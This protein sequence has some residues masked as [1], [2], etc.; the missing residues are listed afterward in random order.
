MFNRL[1]NSFTIKPRILF[2]CL[3]LTG[4]W[5]LSTGSLYAQEGGQIKQPVSPTSNVLFQGRSIDE[6]CREKNLSFVQCQT[7]KSELSKSGG[8]PTPEAIEAL[9]KSPE[10]KDLKPE[11]IAKGKELLEKKEV[12]EPAKPEVPAGEDTLFDRYISGISP[13]E[14]RI[15]LKSSEGIPVEPDYII[16]TGDKINILL[17]GKANAQYSLTVGSDGTILFPNVGPLYVEGM[18]FEEVKKLL[19]KQTEN[20][21]GIT[22]L[23]PFGYNLFTETT[24]APQQNLPIASDYIIGPSDEINIFLWGRINAQYNLIVSR[25]GTIQVPNMG[26]LSVAGMTFE[27]VKKFLAKQAKN[28]VGAE[29]N[30]TM[31]MLRSIQV[32]VLG[33]VKKPG[34]YTVSAMSTLT[35]ALM[36]SGGPTQIGTLR[37]VELKRNNNKTIA[38][39]DFYDLLLKGDK[40]KDMRL[41]N[42]DVVFVPTAGPLV[43]VAGNVKRPAIYELKGETDLAG[44]LELAG[45]IIP[46]AYTQQIQVERVE[47]NQRRIVV[48]LNT[49]ERDIA[50]TF[51]LQ[52]ADLVKVFSIVDKDTNVVY[53]HGNVKRPGKYEL[54]K[55]MRL[56]N[57]IKDESELLQETYFEYGLIKRLVPPSFEVKLIP[58]SLGSL[59]FKSSQED[60]IELTPRDSIYI[61]SKWLFKD[62]PSASI[63]GEVRKKGSFELGDNFSVKDLVLLA[64]D[65]TKEAY[66]KKAEIVRVN[67]K[68]EYQ[69]I[70]FNLVKAMAGDKSENLILQD[71]DKVIIHSMWEE[72]WKEIVTIVGEVKK[73]R[74]KDSQQ[75]GKIEDIRV[76]RLQ[77]DLETEQERLKKVEEERKSLLDKGI[78]TPTED[79]IKKLDEKIERQKQKIQEGED[80]LSKTEKEIKESM[81]FLLTDEMTI[82]DLMFKAGG[83]TRDT[84]LEEA[85]L[86]RTDWKT[87]EV[88]LLKFNL[89]KAMEGDEVNNIK[90]QDLDRV[91]IHSI[92][93]KIPR[94]Y[95]TI[96]GEVNKPGQYSYAANMTVRDFVFAAGSLFESAYLEEAELSSYIVKE[97][98]SSLISYRKVNLREAMAGEPSQNIRL[99]P[100]DALFI[101]RVPEWKEE[102]YIII[103]GEVVFPGRYIFKKGERLSS[104]IERAG[105][106][107]DKAYLN[108]ALFTRESVRVLQQKNLD[109]SIDRMEQMLL[110]QTVGAVETA[111]TPEAS[112]QQ[113]AAIEQRKIL[114]SKLRATKA[115]GRLTIK[116][117]TPGK[118][119]GTSH[120][121]EIEDKDTIYIPLQ[122]SSVIVIGAVF[123]QNAFL[124]DAKGNVSSYIKLAG[125]MTREADEKSIFILK[126]DGTA[127]S[128]RQEGW[129]FMS[130][131]LDAGD[132]VIVPQ[133]YEK[134]AWLRE[135]RDI[136]QI[137]YQVAITTGTLKV[138]GL[139]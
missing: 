79:L 102:K 76:K 128:K 42:G 119:K 62:K 55:G 14:V 31:G 8:Q 104:I 125:G 52:D 4:Y 65:L 58:F 40:S 18:T 92:W 59:L 36:A 7:L 105:G 72:K 15:E 63:E 29:I 13:I 117:N 94:Q 9:K 131:R 96:S 45:G 43:G 87:K 24:L 11:E 60:N 137:L 16:K 5:L 122:P 93:E 46:T 47:K 28:I 120:D 70:Y 136:T 71:E 23:R 95:V 84:H 82:K 115:L 74:E 98:K 77:T 129:G 48:D 3:L 121:I 49:I 66:L 2:C 39:M 107:T 124:Y 37:K 68:R 67:K 57:L 111:L 20:I 26:V 6:I 83:G 33:E 135:I 41:Q 139:F 112:Q 97:G 127:L 108:G 126:S 110:S 91:I 134:V 69:T 51:K 50:K 132:A 114:L 106:F 101:K 88:T 81:E 118:L 54:K 89:A 75:Q 80:T 90:L 85:E 10:F 113:K 86:Y 27:E 78:I 73:I 22:Q 19:T 133:E 30:V 32:F 138:M 109:E 38:I 123:N 103:T 17:L 64:G 34:A 12:K 100:Y 99:N 1:I 116:L 61:F 21:V 130:M 35:N 56:K 44:I 25:D 53:L